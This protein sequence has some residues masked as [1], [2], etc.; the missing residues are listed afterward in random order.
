MEAAA[1][2]YAE[3]TFE[4]VKDSTKNPFKKAL[5]NYFQRYY[6]IK[7]KKNLMSGDLKIKAPDGSELS[8]GEAIMRDTKEVGI[9]RIVDGLMDEDNYHIFVSTHF[10]EKTEYDEKATEVVRQAI[11]DYAEERGDGA[12]EELFKAKLRERVAKLRQE[13]EAEGEDAKR[14]DN[15][16]EIAENAIKI[17]EQ[18]NGKLGIEKVLEGFAVYNAT[19]R[20]K[21]RSK[22]KQDKI[23]KLLEKWE[24]SKISYFI[25]PETVAIA[26]GVATV[27]A[28]SGLSRLARIIL[29]VGGV[30]LSGAMSG[31]RERRRVTI[32]RGKMMRDLENGVEFDTDD[33]DKT[34]SR[35]ERKR[36]RYNKRLAGSDYP[37]ESA[38][39]LISNIN[40]ALEGEDDEAIFKAFTAARVRVVYS[41][42]NEM[43]LIGASE[44]ST[45]RKDRRS[46]AKA[47]AEARTRLKS[48]P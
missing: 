41:E 6:K 42:V 45:S 24:N 28:K 35:F 19:I 7:Y 4:Q 36:A 23:D 31:A 10:G 11:M 33:E 47:M 14:V 48:N 13:G 43:G 29:P 38:D 15:Y 5:M 3:R 9:A 27:L 20:D 1:K 32:D 25:S 34:K 40:K 39:V 26:T 21:E 37:I 8:I 46:L 18:L 17:K 2:Y 16:F 44:G 12:D 22:E 30:L